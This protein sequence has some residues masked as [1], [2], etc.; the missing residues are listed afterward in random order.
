MSSIRQEQALKLISYRPNDSVTISSASRLGVAGEASG[1]GNRLA[2]VA[3]KWRN[4]FVLSWLTGAGLFW[5]AIYW[6]LVL[7]NAPAVLPHPDGSLNGPVSPLAA[8]NQATFGIAAPTGVGYVWLSCTVI[9]APA[10]QPDGTI[11]RH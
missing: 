10:M 3:N 7:Q 8:G 4:T 11:W 6:L 9:R 2:V 1:T 5:P